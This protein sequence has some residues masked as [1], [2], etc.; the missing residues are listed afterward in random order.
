MLKQLSENSPGLNLIPDGSD[1]QFPE[2]TNPSF[3]DIKKSLPGGGGDHGLKF[4][5]APVHRNQEADVV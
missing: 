4:G 2:V 1:A 5:L 3:K